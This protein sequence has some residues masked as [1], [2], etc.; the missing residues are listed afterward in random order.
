MIPGF[1]NHKTK[2]L[3]YTR[4]FLGS[5]PESEAPYRLKIDHTFRVVGH[6]LQYTEPLPDSIRLAS[7]IAAL[8]HDLGRFSQYKEFS[9]FHDGS[10]CNHALRSVDE[11]EKL[12][13]LPPSQPYRKEIIDAI[14]LH[15]QKRLSE[16]LPPSSTFFYHLLRDCDKTDVLAVLKGHYQ[17]A[18]N[19]DRYLTLGLSEEPKISPEVI[20]ALEAGH[21]VDLR[22]LRTV[23]DFKLLQIGW[24]FDIRHRETYEFILSRK[25]FQAILDTIPPDLL[26]VDFRRNFDGMLKKELD[27]KV[28]VVDAARQ[29]G[30]TGQ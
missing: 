12:G 27:R 30:L 3:H 16:P 28:S 25:D 7:A 20:A 10:S 14:R 24:I 18:G 1:A 8:Y 29:A 22:H 11:L 9:T 4:S 23:H 5:D 6:S 15:N 21:I 13:F 2:F 26:P 17:S 19:R